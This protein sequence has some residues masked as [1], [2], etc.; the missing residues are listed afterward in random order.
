M[1][2]SRSAM[3]GPTSH[4]RRPPVLYFQRSGGMLGRSFA[5][6]AYLVGPSNTTH[7]IARR[8]QTYAG[9]YQRQRLGAF[10]DEGERDFFEH[11]EL[12]LKRL[13]H[14]EWSPELEIE[15]PTNAALVSARRELRRI[16]RPSSIFPSI[17]PDGEGGVDVTWMAGPQRLSIN[18]DSSGV[19]SA[20][21]VSREGRVLVDGTMSGRRAVL[22]FAK[23]LWELSERIERINPNWRRSFGR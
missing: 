20:Y 13:E 21:A 9:S 14:P 19:V 5:H 6:G 12:V 16:A 18:I 22:S 7:D 8:F 15:P 11:S 2:P 1:A 4:A 10:P 23:A 17:A 3:F